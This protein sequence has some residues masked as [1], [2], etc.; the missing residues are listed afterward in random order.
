M[1]L[2]AALP[3]GKMLIVDDVE[4]NR[5]ILSNI[6]EN[7]YE[8]MEAENGREA[9]AL[10]TKES[11]RIAAILLDVVMPEMDGIELL[12]EMK[13]QS[14][15]QDIPVFLITADASEKNMYLGYELGVKDIIEKPFIPH[16][17]EQRING[18]VELY[19]TKAK[20][21]DTISHQAE[22]IEEK[23]REIREI[24]SSML[25]ALALAIEFRSGETGQHVYNIR[26]LTVR[27]LYAMREHGVE[28]CDFTDEQI[29]QISV[30]AILHDLGKI[31]VPDSILNKP[32]R[33][34]PEE[35][36][37]MKEHTVKGA[38]LLEKLPN[39]EKNA[40]FS[41]AWDICRHHHERWDGSGYPD[42]L[43]GNENQIYTQVVSMADVYDALI[44][45]RCYKKPFSKE[46]AV[47]MMRNGE[48]GVFHP[49]LLKIFLS[50]VVPNRE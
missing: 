26:D 17:L 50:D 35:F 18:V 34:T 28:G 15:G 49:E 19:Q 25:E 44:S 3:K 2:T 27:S 48:C 41:Y 5:A 14:L 40:L 21:Q 20:L 42:G 32:G 13:K 30:A 23:V 45:P 16:F 7:Q 8:I 9:L 38:E 37:I 31:S 46:D 47:R 22:I 39:R 12:R 43:R 33:L 24:S 29:G 10:I 4:L 11:P 36:E 1:S 6:F